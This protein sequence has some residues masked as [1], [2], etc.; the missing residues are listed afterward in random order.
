MNV[1]TAL[2]GGMMVWS[3]P[4]SPADA[5]VPDFRVTPLV[6]ADVDLYL[7]TMHA[8]ADAV[9]KAKGTANADVTIADNHGV[10][11]HYQAV[12][13]EIETLI[14]PQAAPAPKEDAV[15]AADRQLLAPHTDEIVTLQQQVRGSN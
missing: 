9:A 1:F 4:V 13:H 14:G 11:M 3:Y 2:M 6:Q 15:V 7:N 10:G 12:R 8:A 5:A